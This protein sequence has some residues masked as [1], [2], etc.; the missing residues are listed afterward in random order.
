MTLPE[1]GDVYIH[2]VY[3]GRRNT[4]HSIPGRDRETAKNVSQIYDLKSDEDDDSKQK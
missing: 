1:L 4:L 3:I 2:Y